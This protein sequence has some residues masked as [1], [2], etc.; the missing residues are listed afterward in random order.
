MLT[1]ARMRAA[2]TA[3]GAAFEWFTH[4]APVELYERLQRTGLEPRQPETACV[5]KE[6]L[7]AFGRE[8]AK[9]VCLSPFPKRTPLLLNKGGRSLCKLAAPFG[10]ILERIGVDWSF[11]DTWELADR[12]SRD[13]PGLP[14]ERVFME[15]VRD[16]EVV[17]SC[18]PLTAPA[19]RVC[20]K[21]APL[22]HPSQWPILIETA[23]AEVQ[24]FEPDII[25]N[26]PL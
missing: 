24:I 6:V 12:L 25:G 9:I 16:R 7:D 23:V 18:D 26:V 4:A 19:L 15:V 1:P 17:V 21:N 2:R 5:P 8:G 20:P 10:A 14:D 22:S 13:G 3:L 11:G